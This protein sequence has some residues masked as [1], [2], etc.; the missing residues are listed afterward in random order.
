MYELQGKEVLRP[1]RGVSDTTK[2]NDRAELKMGQPKASHM[3]QKWK[4][5][6]G[7]ARVK[8]RLL[9]FGDL[10]ISLVSSQVAKMES[11]NESDNQTQL[12]PYSVDNGNAALTSTKN[13][14]KTGAISATH[15]R[16]LW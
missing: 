2:S 11:N 4:C 9:G 14:I 1:G 13:W 8:D 7:Q 10:K 6:V 5:S 15:Q 12:P 16:Y 3:C